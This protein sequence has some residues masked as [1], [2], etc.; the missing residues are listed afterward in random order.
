MNRRGFTLLEVVIAITILALV[1]GSIYGLLRQSVMA[2]ADLESAEKQD[3]AI[4]HFIELCRSTLEALP[5][6]ASLTA[7]LIEEG[8]MSQEL[9]I[10]GVFDAFS[11]GEDPVSESDTVLGLQPYE[12]PSGNEAETPLYSVAITR[13]DF[14]PQ[15]EDG[16]MAIRVGGNDEFFAPDDEGRY[17]LPLLPAVS[18][19]QWQF[20]DEEEELWIETW[21]D[22]ETR[23]LMVELQLQP[24]SRS[25]PIRVVYDIP[26]VPELVAEDTT[27]TSSAGATRDAAQPPAQGNGNGGAGQ[28]PQGR[29]GDGAAGGRRPPGAGNGGKGRPQRPPGGGP[30]GGRG[31]GPQQGGGNGGRGG[32]GGGGPAGGGGNGGNAGGGG[33]GPAGGGGNAGGGGGAAPAGGGGGAQ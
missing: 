13:E 15:A 33:D 21:E 12:L 32:Q 27:A 16:E 29:P 19:L 26:P 20:W 22:A 4:H 14:A 7:E 31:G 17:W 3:Q 25:T 2:A 6:E 24:A 9:T 18:L 30:G 8:T 23:P 5:G 1:T 11:F 28:R 10:S